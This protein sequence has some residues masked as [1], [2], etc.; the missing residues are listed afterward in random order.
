MV[1]RDTIQAAWLPNEPSFWQGLSH[2]LLIHDLLGYE[3]LSSG[4]WYVAIDFQLYA[5]LMCLCHAMH[6]ESHKRLSVVVA[7]LCVASMWQFNRIDELDVWAIYFFAA[8]GLGVLAAWAKRSVFETRVFWITAL[9]AV[10]ALWLEYRTRLSLALVTAIWLVIKP[11]GMVHWTPMKRV[12]HR[13]SNSAYVLFLT[14]FGV[15]VL[16]SSMWN[17]SHFY[18]PTMAFVLTGFAWMCCVSMGLFMHEKIEVP[19]HHWVSQKSKK[20]LMHLS[21]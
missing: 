21:R 16:F 19:M 14:H 20:L 18:D 13:L 3:A 4:A 6:T 2:A 11:K 8:Y 17:K 10:G 15:I 12:V 1:S 5:L 7:L 9:L